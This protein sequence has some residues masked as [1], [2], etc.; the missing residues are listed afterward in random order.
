MHGWA[1]SV[2]LLFFFLRYHE[3]MLFYCIFQGHDESFCRRWLCAA[4]FFF[5]LLFSLSPLFPS[6]LYFFPEET[7]LECI[8]LVGCLWYLSRVGA[9]R[10]SLFSLYGLSGPACLC[11]HVPTERP[12]HYELGSISG[13]GNA[14]VRRGGFFFLFSCYEDSIIGN[15][16]MI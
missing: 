14:R 12:V 11:A 2:T 10:S 13:S 4:F 15:T 6:R 8:I 5:F 16:V 9:C 7:P 3:S 1:R